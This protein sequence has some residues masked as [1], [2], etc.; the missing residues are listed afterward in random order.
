VLGK[1]TSDRVVITCKERFDEKFPHILST[2]TGLASEELK[3]FIASEREL[4]LRELIDE[5]GK[6]ESKRYGT[7]YEDSY[8]HA[9]KEIK[10]LIRK[11]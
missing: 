2:G 9:L 8:N 11:M 7:V 6:I 10:E 3:S 1:N 5:I 4:L